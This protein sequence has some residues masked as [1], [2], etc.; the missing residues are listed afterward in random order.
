MHCR[1]HIFVGFFP[2]MV[3]SP[4][5]SWCEYQ[6]SSD[7][8]MEDPICPEGKYHTLSKIEKECLTAEQTRLKLAARGNTREAW[9]PG[10]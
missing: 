6:S 8:I 9:S 3:W 10:R 1:K 7:G 2:G 4:E 5:R